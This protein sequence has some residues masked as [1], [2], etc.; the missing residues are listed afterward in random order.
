MNRIEQEQ[1]KRELRELVRQK[2][3]FEIK[4]KCFE[5]IAQSITSAIGKQRGEQVA[6]LREEAHKLGYLL[7]KI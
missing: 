3:G 5:P 6:K 7:M 1:L 4:M 2:T